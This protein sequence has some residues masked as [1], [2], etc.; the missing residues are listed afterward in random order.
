MA[1]KYNNARVKTDFEYNI[2]EIS[3]DFGKLFEN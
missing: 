3:K 2:Y 1:K